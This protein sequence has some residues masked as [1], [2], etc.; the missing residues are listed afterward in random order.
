MVESKV[1]EKGERRENSRVKLSADCLA[2]SLVAY[3]VVW[4]AAPMAV[5]MA[6]YFF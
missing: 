2:E 5:T 3:L 1:R 4:W 6:D